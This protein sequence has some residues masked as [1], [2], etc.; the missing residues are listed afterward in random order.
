MKIG[1][2][3][4]TLIACLRQVDNQAELTYQ[5][6]LKQ[7]LSW[8]VNITHSEGKTPEKTL[9]RVLQELRDQ[10]FLQFCG[11]GVYKLIQKEFPNDLFHREKLSKGERLIKNVL[12]ELNIPIHNEKTFADLK[13]K[14]YLRYDYYF[15]VGD[16]RFVIEYHG[17][18]HYRPITYFGGLLNFEQS[19][20]R[21]M[22]KAK[23]ARDNQITMITVSK[24]NP[25]LA[26][27]TIA[28]AVHGTMTE[29]TLRSGKAL[30]KSTQKLINQ[31]ITLGD[32]DWI[33]EELWK[34]L[35]RTYVGYH[36][37]EQ[38]MLIHGIN[39]GVEWYASRMA[40]NL[41]WSTISSENPLVEYPSASRVYIFTKNINAYTRIL[42]DAKK[43]QC[44]VYHIQSDATIVLCA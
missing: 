19:L 8:I 23:Y 26:R 29:S 1:W 34:L 35:Y 32:D 43:I 18:Q 14:S 40:G 11:R 42:E 5:T 4:S 38:C 28:Q 25:E 2:T 6:L 37:K 21:D 13:Y 41:G 22:I 39:M 44:P 3:L 20:I 30:V 10:E 33:G 15:E 36:S 7:E 24:I 27:K 31:V 12:T 9:S 16:R 17:E